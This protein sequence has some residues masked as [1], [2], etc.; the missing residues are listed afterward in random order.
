MAKFINNE[1]PKGWYPQPYEWV[2]GISGKR[3]YIGQVVPA[4]RNPRKPA[5][6][7]RHGAVFCYIETEDGIKKAC[8]ELK[9]L[10]FKRK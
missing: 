2:E 9:P 7:Q 4:K 8:Y 6:F 5:I 3:K 10:R 1:V